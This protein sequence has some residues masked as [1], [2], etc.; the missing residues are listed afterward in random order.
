MQKI[1]K[2][3]STAESLCALCLTFVYSAVKKTTNDYKLA[4]KVIA[5]NRTDS[6]AILK[7]S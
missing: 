7:Y 3:L 6:N 4:F 1:A 2:D 5:F